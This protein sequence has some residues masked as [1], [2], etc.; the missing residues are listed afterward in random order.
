MKKI[1]KLIDKFKKWLIVKLGGYAYPYSEVKTYRPRPDKVCTFLELHRED[2]VSEEFLKR[3][4][5]EQLA[6]EIVKSNLYEIE[7]SENYVN[8]SIVH[9]MTVFA[10][11]PRG[12]D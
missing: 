4:L 11:N 6:E 5:A 12:F 7:R 8:N 2:C 3:R 1:K 10:L 9:R